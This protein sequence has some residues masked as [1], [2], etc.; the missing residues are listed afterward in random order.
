M[1]ENEGMYI[2]YKS[3]FIYSSFTTNRIYRL[4]FAECF[5]LYKRT[6]N[7]GYKIIT[8]FKVRVYHVPLSL[9]LSLDILL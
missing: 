1:F 5:P 6:I 2:T 4:L 3:T 8:C 9:F 7:E